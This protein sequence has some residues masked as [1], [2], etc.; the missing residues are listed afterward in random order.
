MIHLNNDTSS[1]AAGDHKMKSLHSEDVKVALQSNTN[2][3]TDVDVPA[4]LQYTLE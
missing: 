4:N 3:H 1:S 2:E